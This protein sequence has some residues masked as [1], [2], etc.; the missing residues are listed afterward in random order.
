MNLLFFFCILWCA[1]SNTISS[2]TNSGDDDVDGK[3]P[4]YFAYITTLTGGFT[5]SGGIPVV[6]MALQ[7][8]NSRD[9]ILQNYTLKHTEVLDSGV[10]TCIYIVCIIAC[11]HSTSIL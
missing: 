1:F 8:I 9:D 10:S 7:E 5:A 6:D 2:A 11:R 3:T 4:L